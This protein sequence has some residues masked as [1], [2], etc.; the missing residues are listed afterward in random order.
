MKDKLD[1]KDVIGATVLRSSGISE[2]LK[3]KG[4]YTAKCFD[5]N[6]NLKW[7]DTIENLVTDVGANQ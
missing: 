6:G 3:L 7:E 5:K 1:G 2:M 4:K